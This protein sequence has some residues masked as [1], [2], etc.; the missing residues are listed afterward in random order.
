M[1]NLI[2]FLGRNKAKSFLN[3]LSDEMLFKYSILSIVNTQYDKLAEGIFAP[4]IYVS[5]SY[6]QCGKKEKR[7]DRNSNSNHLQRLRVALCD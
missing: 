6:N 3:Y 5:K 7:W 1:V 2:L 4:L